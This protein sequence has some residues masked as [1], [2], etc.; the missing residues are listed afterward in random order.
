MKPRDRVVTAEDIQNSLYFVHVETPEDS[1]LVEPIPSWREPQYQ[2]HSSPQ[3]PSQP[4]GNPVQRKA[5]PGSSLAPTLPA[6][7]KRKPVPGS[8]APATDFQ[9]RQNVDASN[10]ARASSNLVPPEY[11]PRRSFDSLQYQAENERSS[12]S[13]TRSTS[14]SS[15]TSLTLIRRDPASGAQWNVARI[16]DPPI[17]DVSSSIMNDQPKKQVGAPLFVDITNPGYSKFL[18]SEPLGMPSS[19][20]PDTTGVPQV[21][22]AKEGNVFRRRLWMEGARNPNGG[23][24]H[25]RLD[26]HESYASN[27][28]ARNSSE[29]RR[30]RSSMDLRRPE[31]PPFLTRENQSYNS[32]QVSNRQSTFRGYVFMSPW[33]GR[34]EF[35]TGAGGGSLKVSACCSVVVFAETYWCIV[36]TFGP[37]LARGTSIRRVCQ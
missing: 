3:V 5:I 12:F 25:Q 8:L 22:P 24:G 15:G 9:N 32:I 11:P 33:N 26:S 29:D 27:G 28:S 1:R 14:V 23:F 37:R 16:E 35:L 31:A 30:N 17:S 34:C 7:P 10:Y 21:T 19:G 20:T 4:Q 2:E 18:R 6:G 13:S 36:S